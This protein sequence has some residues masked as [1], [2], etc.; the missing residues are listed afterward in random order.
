MASINKTTLIGNITREIEIRYTP[1]GTAI[2]E[3]GLALNRKYTTDSGE[4]REECTFLDITFF[5]KSA[6]TIEKYC[7]KG[8]LIYIE[9]R[10]TLDT[11]DDKET[12][13]KRSK[14]KLIGEQFQFIGGGKKEGESDSRES[15]SSQRPPQGRPAG[16]QQPQ[17]PPVDPDLD[18]AEDDCPF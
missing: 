4:K 5:A 2:I 9:A 1:K 18:R 3:L 10:L 13:K 15:R 14:L 11:W 6:E 17:R 7:K 16:R 8:D 12:G